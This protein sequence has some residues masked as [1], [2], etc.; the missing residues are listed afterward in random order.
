ME[1]DQSDCYGNLCDK[2]DDDDKDDNDDDED[3]LLLI[4]LD[5]SRNDTVVVQKIRPYI[6]LYN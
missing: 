5:H 4:I 2:D 1:V 6:N 3:G